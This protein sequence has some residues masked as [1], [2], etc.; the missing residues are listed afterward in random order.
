MHAVLALLYAGREGWKMNEDKEQLI[1]FAEKL[2][3]EA[4]D[5]NAYYLILQQYQ[6]NQHDYPE[7]MKISPVFY[8]SV[9]EALIKACFM[10]IAKLFDASNDAVSIGTLLT[11]C[12]E[13]QDFFPEYRETMNVEYGGRTFSYP[14]PYQHRLKPQEECFFKEQVEREREIFAEFDI[15]NAAKAAIQ[16]DLTFPEFLNLYQ[17]RFNALNK[18]KEKV[19]IQ[20]NKMY[21]HND[22]QYILSGGK[23]T[24]CCISF[25]DMH[26]MID[27]ALD[28]SGLILGTL[29][30]A[31]HAKKYANIDDW[32]K[33]LM[34]TRIGM[35][36]QDY[37]LQ[38]QE[39]NM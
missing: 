6:K 21:A 3:K 15:S 26:E 29:T 10:E 8:H 38:Q 19:R 35:K 1:S 32:E 2:Y 37:D 11:R 36:Y 39:E 31:D 7:E 4:F 33:T 22:E 5:A 27:F 23:Q 12:T 9:Y 17:K 24:N 30:D 14:I 34:L 18:K 25:E 20:R 16:V 28:C 13:H